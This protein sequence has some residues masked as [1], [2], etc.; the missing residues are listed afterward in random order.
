MLKFSNLN[1]GNF[2]KKAYLASLTFLLCFTVFINNANGQWISGDTL[3]SDF[4][5]FRKILAETHPDPYSGFGG[6]VFFHKEAFNVEQ[7]LKNGASLDEF[8][9]LVLSFISNMEDGHTFINKP[10]S[11]TVS[12]SSLNLPL[13]FM[14]TQDGLIVSKISGDLKKFIGSKIQSING[15][16]LQELC[17]KVGKLRPTEN[18][19]HKY[20]LLSN[21]I[22]NYRTMRTIFPDWPEKISIVL[23]ILDGNRETIELTY[24]DNESL[25]NI[26]MVSIPKYAAIQDDFLFHDYLD[27]NKQAMYFRISTI[28][29]REPFIYMKENGWSDLNRTLEVVYKNNLNQEMP[30]DVDEAIANIPIF[31]QVFRE[32]L[33]RMKTDRAKYLILDLR[34][35]GGGFTP[36]TLPSLYMLFG[37]AYLE[38][39][40]DVQFYRLISPLYLKKI[41]V[42]LEDLNKKNNTNYEYGD[43]P[44]SFNSEEKFI[45]IAERRNQFVANAMG[46][47]AEYI[48][49]LNG[50]PVYSPEKIFVITNPG[51]FSAAF[52]YAFYLWKMGATVIGVP[53]GQAPNTFMENTPFELPLT[54]LTG[55][56]SNS[57]QVFL[58]ANDPKAKIFY[59]D[60]MLNWNDYKKY[61]FNKDS[62]LLYLI[63]YL[64]LKK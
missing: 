53:S 31:A 29:A 2:Q 39:D 50:K 22:C 10:Q 4:K 20:S 33:E 37:D 43:Y 9:S 52:H 1:K 11:N 30:E 61:D 24:L 15:V 18:I 46:G 26:E 45:D 3:T 58:P 28:M 14:V 44:M 25:A 57:L 63:D 12:V 21:G 51:T 49:D 32:V 34:A 56:I 47:A 38:K 16:S 6:K 59:P 17:K 8:T 19:F 60:I 7:K 35:N 62:D 36:M 40:M 55:S 41:N 64:K 27:K 42:D 23:E 5:Y 54:K 13:G 48:K